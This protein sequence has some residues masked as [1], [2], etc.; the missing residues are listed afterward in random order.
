M[1]YE[2]LPVRYIH[3]TT[4]IA[5]RTRTLVRLLDDLRSV[6]PQALLAARLVGGRAL[7]EGLL[8]AKVGAVV[9]TV[10][11]RRDGARRSGLAGLLGAFE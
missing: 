2:T 6:E 4:R 9:V 8:L 7:V 5:A 10:L 11:V 1:T 3:I